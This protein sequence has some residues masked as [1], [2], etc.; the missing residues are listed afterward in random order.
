[1]LD[2]SGKVFY[3]FSL[4]VCLDGFTGTEPSLSIAYCA[5]SD[6][7]TRSRNSSAM[8]EFIRTFNVPGRL[9]TVPSDKVMVFFD[10]MVPQFY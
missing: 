7:T 2:D 1:M 10:L 4:N 8:A 6:P 9:D 5:G 3:K